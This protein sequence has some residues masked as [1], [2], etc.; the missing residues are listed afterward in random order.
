MTSWRPGDGPPPDTEPYRTALTHS[1][2]AAE[3][4]GDH[5]ER[6]EF[7]GDAVLQLYTSE[8][9][10]AAFP[11]AAEGE[12]SRCR[13]QLVNTDHLAD[14]ATV[15]DLGRCARLG[16]GEAATGG[17]RRARLLAGLYEAILAAVY[18]D[19]GHAAAREVVK[20]AQEPHLARA[21][22]DH[23]PK[24]QL[25]EWAQARGGAVPHY[26]LVGQEGPA[27]ARRFCVEVSIEARPLARGWGTRK[28]K[29][30]HAAAR[31]AL[32]ELEE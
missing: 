32:G 16:R 19:Q 5:N 23:N 24:Q 10:C 26:R 21:R 6:L 27:H 25:Q 4:G 22:S 15:A 20:R 14:L 17:A 11:E 2:W 13:Q 9:L 12:L 3:H 8:L 1:S 29:A 18:V 28:K 30:E 31:A 7:L